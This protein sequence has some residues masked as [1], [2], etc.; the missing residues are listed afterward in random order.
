MYTANCFLYGNEYSV[1]NHVVFIMIRSQY[2]RAENRRKAGEGA[3]LMNERLQTHLA[4]IQQ[5][6]LD[7]G[8]MQLQVYNG[9]NQLIQLPASSHPAYSLS[10]DVLQSMRENSL[11]Q[12]MPTLWGITKTTFYVTILLDDEELLVIGPICPHPPIPDE[13]VET[14][15]QLK[16]DHSVIHISQANA[17]VICGAAVTITY[18]L[19][20]KN[21]S[22][23]R[24]YDM[25]TPF[26]DIYIP[27]WIE[28]HIASTGEKRM[29][30][31]QEQQW[32]NDI[33]KGKILYDS[34]YFQRMA[35][36]K[37][38]L[39]IG[40]LADMPMKQLEYQYVSA[41]VLATRAIIRGGVSPD[42]AYELEESLL[43]EIAKA[44]TQSQLEH[45]YIMSMRSLTSEVLRAQADL[46][47]SGLVARCKLYVDNA[48]YEKI[49]VQSIAEKM[50]ISANHLSSVFVKSEGITL[51]EYIHRKR[52]DRSR[53]LLRF[54]TMSITEISEMLMFS[55]QSHFCRLFR[56][57][58]QLTPNEY[59]KRHSWKK[60]R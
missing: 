29:T 19:T 2:K 44:Q 56:Q 57:A 55:S 39:H 53:E 40:K 23:G 26:A 58:F 34:E 7:S 35:Q 38:Q 9:Q 54:S 15:K 51:T 60:T 12:N 45:I 13:I 36:Q 46:S 6:L 16:L 27:Q 31:A 14:A 49:T 24:V 50:E 17:S 20:G 5:F 21:Y 47:Q 22:R 59:R 28:H 11:R 41:I 18:L 33:A 8:N 48:M 25:N 43:Q 4:F 42:G 1:Y 37:E 10:E 32:L 3:N 52:L 30:Y